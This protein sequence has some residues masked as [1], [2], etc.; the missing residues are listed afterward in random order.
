MYPDTL[1]LTWS[2]NTAETPNL[3]CPCPDTGW[4]AFYFPSTVL[5]LQR[6]PSALQILNLLL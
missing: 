1:T 6:H 4:T 3:D 5:A 2:M